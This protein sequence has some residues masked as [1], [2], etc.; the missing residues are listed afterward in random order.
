MKARVLNRVQVE[1][2]VNVLINKESKSRALERTDLQHNIEAKITM[3]MFIIMQEH[4]HRAANTLNIKI[5]LNQWVEA[6]KMPNTVETLPETVEV[7]VDIDHLEI[8]NIVLPSLLK[9]PV[10]LIP[11]AQEVQ[12]H[13]AENSLWMILT[14]A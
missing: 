7:K 13:M 5:L 6:D 12:V 3:Q 4:L 10:E 9:D 8:P 14:T 1:V 2:I 11:E